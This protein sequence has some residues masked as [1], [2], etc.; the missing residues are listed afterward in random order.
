MQITDGVRNLA[1]RIRLVDDRGHL[2]RLDEFLQD[3]R[4]SDFTFPKRIRSRWLTAVLPAVLCT[5]G[6]H[7]KYGSAIVWKRKVETNQ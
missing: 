2:A 4:S 5:R 6:Y 3:C 1:E 7:T